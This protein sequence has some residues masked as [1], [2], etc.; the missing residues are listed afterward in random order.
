M[1]AAGSPGVVR[2]LGQTAMF[3]WRVFRAAIRPRPLRLLPRQLVKY[4]HE[5]GAR[6]VLLVSV[7]CAF[8]GAML[9]VQGFATLHML[10]APELL[11]MFIGLGGVREVFPLVAAGTVGARA[12]CAIAAEIATLQIG[13]QIDALE[14]MSVDPVAYLVAPRL[15]AAVLVTPLVMAVGVLAGLGAAYL[16]AVV[17][18]GVD[19]GAYLARAYGP[20]SY[21]DSVGIIVKGLVFGVIV[22]VV[23]SIEGFRARGGAAGVGVA[24]NRAVVRAMV[25]GSVV[26][27]ALSQ[28]LFGGM[29]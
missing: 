6:S 4:A 20:L 10:G 5:I 24:A 18:L 23:T 16:T 9:A 28:L 3:T 17:Q 14:V 25:A 1:S 15:L 11:G 13:E 7:V 8:A 19:P 2:D 21:H 26:N 22:V 29:E 12:G 27:L